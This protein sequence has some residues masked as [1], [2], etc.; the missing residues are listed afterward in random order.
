MKSGTKEI[1][2]IATLGALSAAARVPFAA[3][4]GV[5]PSTFLIIVSGYVFGPVV[6]LAVGALTAILSNMFLG[7]GPWTLWQM[8]VW[9]LAGF[10]A[11]TV[12]KLGL[13]L[14]KI[15]LPIFCLLWGFI[16]GF[17]INL[18]F[19]ATFIRPATSLTFFLSWLSGTPH[20][21]LHAMGNLIFALVF[22]ATAIKIMEKFKRRFHIEYLAD[23][24]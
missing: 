11:G 10:S 6:G 8:V 12:R 23:E 21:F 17:L 19:W 4:P 24:I 7:Q 20:D 16:Y 9:G 1:S 3:I 2:L 22:G 18:W 13:R 5:Q 15:S 14:G